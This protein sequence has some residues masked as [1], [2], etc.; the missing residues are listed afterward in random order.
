MLRTHTCGDLRKNH[1]GLCVELAG[2]VDSIRQSGKIA[3]IDLRDMYGVT[4]VFLGP[5]LSV[6]CKDFSKESVVRIFGKVKLRP[7]SNPDLMTGEIEVS[8]ENIFILNK[9]DE[10]PIQL[11]DSVSTS[12]EMRLKYRYI[13]LRKKRNQDNLIL[14][15][16][17]AQVVRK[18]L[19]ENNF[20][21]V[22]TPI[23]AKSTPEG[24]RDYLVP[25]RVN[26]GKFFALPQAPQQFKQLLM[27][28]GFDRYYQ[29][30][31][32]FRDED[33]RSDRQPEFTQIDIEMGFVEQEDIFYLIEG[34]IKKLW[35]DVL[36]IDLK[37]PFSRLSY[38]DAMRIYDNDR[39]DLRKDKNNKR[40]FSFLWVVDFPLFERGDDEN[41]LSSVH[42]PF[43]A[44][45]D[46]DLGLM[47]KSPIK[48]RSKAYDLVLNGVEL[49]GGSIRIH[50]Q[51]IQMKVFD[52]LGI[53][54]KDVEERFGFLLDALKYGCPPH[55]G[56]AFGFDRLCMMMAGVESIRDVI[57]FPKTKDAEDLMTGSPSDV[58]KAQLDDLGLCLKDKIKK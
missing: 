11:D 49:G 14:R 9:A 17:V 6:L 4:Q 8:A 28:S 2:W 10:L 57:A 45:F 58:D 42:H 33:L 30:A 3:F 18:F 50:S 48:M 41:T 38:A 12:E 35:K 46:D 20:L 1:V 13:D 52:V 24:A 7:Q 23:L 54:K 43:T 34:M 56:I 32:C 40:E 26:N 25:S 5:K 47:K 39:P 55:G 19:N 36:N 29:I 31:K 22:E 21:E 15:H 53:S 44:P 51:D 27:M 37:V 16:R